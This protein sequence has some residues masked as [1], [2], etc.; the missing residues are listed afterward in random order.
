MKVFLESLSLTSGALLIA[1]ISAVAVWLLGTLLPK[2]PRWAWALL[3]PLLLAY[4]VYWS[5]V[6]LG[7]DDV[8]Q[9][10]A[11]AVLVIGTW[12]VA[13]ALASALV[14]FFFRKQRPS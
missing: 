5:P 1:V 14:L 10:S 13:G 8:S 12:F 4:C 11:W 2:A 7:S 9:Y 6:W 3:V